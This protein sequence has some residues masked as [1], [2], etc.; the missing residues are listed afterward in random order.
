MNDI[1]NLQLESTMFFPSCPIG[2]ESRLQANKKTPIGSYIGAKD[3]FGAELTKLRRPRACHEYT[4]VSRV[5]CVSIIPLG[6]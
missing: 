2:I 4:R 6:I 1:E 3:R 5:Q